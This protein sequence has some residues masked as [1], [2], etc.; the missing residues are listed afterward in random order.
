MTN[1]HICD[2]EY[3]DSYT[4]YYLASHTT[5]MLL[6]FTSIASLPPPNNITLSEV[7][8]GQ[9]TFSWS[10][11]TT[12]C[13]SLHYNINVT[14]CGKYSDSLKTTT[15]SFITCNISSTTPSICTLTFQTIVCGG[16]LG[17]ISKLVVHSIQGWYVHS[18]VSYSSA[19]LILL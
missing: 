15:L 2:T 10:P 16:I 1:E 14:N 6:T 9:L 7:S 3:V 18:S 17:T 11:E 8:K 5:S 19:N 4:T 12:N 13:P